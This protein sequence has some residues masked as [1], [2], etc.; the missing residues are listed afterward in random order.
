MCLIGITGLSCKSTLIAIS[1]ILLKQ[2]NM[3]I[4]KLTRGSGHIGRRNRIGQIGF[5]AEKGFVFN[6]FLHNQGHVVCC[7]IMIRIRQTIWI[8][9][10]RICAAKCGSTLIHHV[11]KCFHASGNINGKLGTDFV[12]RCKKNGMKRIFYADRFSKLNVDPGISRNGFADGLFS[13]RDLIGRLF[14]FGD[15]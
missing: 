13:K 5:H 2:H 3:M 14:V 6:C 15:K 9:K 11:G 8:G 1:R 7:G 12:G 10:V 4:L